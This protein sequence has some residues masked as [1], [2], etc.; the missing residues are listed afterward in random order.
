[1]PYV[2]EA[3]GHQVF[4]WFEVTSKRATSLMPEGDVVAE[5][6]YVEF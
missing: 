6:D 4:V 3:A 1:M 2:Y 5:G